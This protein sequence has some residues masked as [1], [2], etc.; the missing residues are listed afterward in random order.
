MLEKAGIMSQNV[1]PWSNPIFIVPKKAQPDELSQKHLCVD[2]CTL[3]S[4][5]PP[6]VKAHS[7]G[8]CIFSLVPLPKMN[9]SYA[10]LNGST[11]YSSLDC[12]SR[13][14]HIALSQKHE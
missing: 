2:Y 8:K 10:M 14:Y 12:T 4:L 13:Y 1:S 3:N 7:K 11:V 6:A 9:E 5:L